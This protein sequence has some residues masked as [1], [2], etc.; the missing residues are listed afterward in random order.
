M[1]EAGAPVAGV[2]RMVAEV[3]AAP[4]MA[5]G[6]PLNLIFK[7]SPGAARNHDS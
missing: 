7:F 3:V 1:L 2:Q 5:G 4:G 6:N